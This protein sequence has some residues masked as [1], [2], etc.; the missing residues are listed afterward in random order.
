MQLLYGEIG[1]RLSEP[2]LKRSPKKPDAQEGSNIAPYAARF[3]RRIR[4]CLVKSALTSILEITRG[5]QL[6]LSTSSV[7]RYNL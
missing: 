2:R 7:A 5:K 3:W 1:A 4:E 6:R